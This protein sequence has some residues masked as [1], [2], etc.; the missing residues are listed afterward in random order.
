MAREHHGLTDTPEY[1]VWSNMKTRCYNPRSIG[2]KDYGAR[3]IRVC[4][5]WVRSFTAFLRDM[6][7][8]PTDQHSIER[9][10]TNADYSPSN[11]VWATPRQQANNKRTTVRLGKDPIAEVARATGVK[12]R[13]LY[14][15]VKRAKRGHDPLGPQLLTLAHA[16]IE[17]T[18]AGWSKR[19]G[20][21]ASTITMRVKKYGWPVSRALTK[22]ASKC[23]PSR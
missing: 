13:T 17:D 11:C 8:R 5:A 16:G 9:L 3:G 2:F 10:D 21:K 1:R 22:G 23:A 19:T 18:V 12:R 15:R 6:G 4:D 7:N 20:I 14:Y